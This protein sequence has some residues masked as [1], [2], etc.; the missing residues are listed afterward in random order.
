MVAFFGVGSSNRVEL[1]S[2]FVL[3]LLGDGR[4][5]LMEFRL[6]R[7]QYHHRLHDG[8]LQKWFKDPRKPIEEF[9][10]RYHSI[11]KNMSTCHG[12]LHLQLEGLSNISMTTLMTSFFNSL[13][14]VVTIKV[15]K[16]K[17]RPQDLQIFVA[18]AR[19]GL[20]IDFKVYRGVNTPFSYRALGVWASVILH[21]SK[22]IPRGSCI[23]FDRYFWSILLLEK[24]TC[25][26]VFNA[27][28]VP[29]TKTK[30]DLEMQRGEPQQFVCD[31]VVVIKLM[32]NKAVLV[33]SNC[34][35]ANETTFVE[36][37]H[38]NTLGY[39]SAPKTIANYNRNM[40]GV[41]I[42]DQSMDYYRTFMMTR[43]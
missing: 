3:Y 31:D 15:I 5:L 18:T 35:S 42:L 20:M 26:M 23:Y 36:R 43:K 10:D 1:T 13:L 25:P 33:A 2:D 11:K 37:W 9:G 21:L 24:L 38:E 16:G 34:T 14:C 6:R 12:L 4:Q 28:D 41:D 22:S 8:T 30:P 7:L 40:G 17:P 27:N 19:E 32:N 39:F 29:N